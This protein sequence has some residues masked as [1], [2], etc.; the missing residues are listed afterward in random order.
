MFPLTG[1]SG[2]GYVVKV[3]RDGAAYRARCFI[4][5]MFLPCIGAH[6]VTAMARV[7]A[8]LARSQPEAVRSLCR[9]AH[10]PE[11][12]CWLHGDGFCLSLRACR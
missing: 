2:R 4:Q 8:A 10:E 11:V 1:S 7:D 6:D 5:V 9:D 3:R 12:D